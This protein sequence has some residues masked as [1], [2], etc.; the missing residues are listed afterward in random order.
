MDW[1]QL[2]LI[3]ATGVIGYL[4]GIVRDRSTA[5]RTKQIEAM[6]RLHERVLEIERK[7]MSDGKSITLSVSVHGGSKKRNSLM[8]DEE[9]SYLS[10]LEHWR[11]ELIEEEDRAQL[12]IDRSTVYLVKHYFLLIMHCK[13][14]EEFGQGLLIE[15]ADFLRY[16]KCIFGRK[17]IFGSA[18][19]VLREITIRNS[20]TGE[21][22]L[23]DCV[24]LSDMCLEVIQ[25]RVRLEVSC[26]FWFRLKSPW[27]KWL[28]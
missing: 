12:W 18:E 26:P 9:V 13:H 15:D 4:F 2:F 7:E 10:I 11:Q 14:W 25:R 19:H 23:V 1:M 20:K 16:L 21:P 28:R 27:W 8:S 17:F 5:V 22:R 24:L 3:L 6:T